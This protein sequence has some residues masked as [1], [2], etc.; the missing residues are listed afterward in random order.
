MSPHAYSEDQLVEQPAIGLFAALGWRM[1][2]GRSPRTRG[3]PIRPVSSTGRSPICSAAS[4]LSGRTCMPKVAYVGGAA[5]RLAAE[6]RDHAVEGRGSPPLATEAGRHQRKPALRKRVRQPISRASPLPQPATAFPDEPQRKDRQPPLRLSPVR[7][8]SVADAAMATLSWQELANGIQ[9]HAHRYG[10]PPRAHASAIPRPFTN[11]RRK[12]GGAMRHGRSDVTEW[13]SGTCR[14]QR[15]EGC[16]GR[17]FPGACQAHS[18]SLAGFTIPHGSYWRMW[19]VVHV[20]LGQSIRIG[21]CR[22]DMAPTGVPLPRC[23][24]LRTSIARHSAGF[25]IYT[26]ALVGRAGG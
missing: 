9:C 19:H 25:A 21:P 12:I 8:I 3:R 10:I 24:G 18:V 7:S 4:A 14:S 11:G 16:C 13:A 22:T 2:L 17:M 20:V 15:P 5:H 23:G 1:A 26:G 6:A